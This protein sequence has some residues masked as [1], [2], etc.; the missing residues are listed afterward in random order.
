MNNYFLSLLLFT[1]TLPLFAHNHNDVTIHDLPL[2]PNNSLT[3]GTLCDED[4]PDFSHLRYDELIP[5]CRRNV[6][7]WDREAVYEKY[8]IP[9]ECRH[10]Y[11][12][13]HFIPLSLGGDNS[14]SNLWPEHEHVQN[15]RSD[16]EFE[17]FLALKNGELTQSE[18]IDIV[19]QAKTTLEKIYIPHH[20]ARDV[21]S[22][23]FLDAKK[24]IS[25]GQEDLLSINNCL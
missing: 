7:R 20:V 4:N 15:M 1:F 14:Y 9:P 3:F 23:D 11:I 18:A 21:F 19:V 6:H 16:L 5:W 24:E 12:I 2:N 25:F 17:T 22:P 8:G 10:R 13:D